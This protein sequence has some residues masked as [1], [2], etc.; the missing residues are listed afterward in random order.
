MFGYIRSGSNIEIWHFVGGI[1]DDKFVKY[2]IDSVNS[3]V[4]ADSFSDFPT[5]GSDN[6]FY[7]DKS[8]W[9]PYVWDGSAYRVIGNP[10]P[11]GSKG[12]TGD[13]GPA[14]SLS[15]GT[16][17][18]GDIADATI[19]GTPPTQILNLVLPKGDAGAAGADGNPT[20]TLRTNGVNNPVQDV[21]DFVDSDT[22]G[23]TY[24]SAGQVKLYTK[25]P[26]LFN[27]KAGT[28]EAIAAG[29][30]VGT[31][32]YTNS[33]LAGRESEVYRSGSLI[34]DFDQGGG[35]EY[36]IKDTDG[37]LNSTTINFLSPIQDGEWIKIK[38]V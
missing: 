31:T 25:S 33:K 36:A 8:T 37:T 2:G 12:D 17:T 7:I 38:L 28:S 10:G 15:I 14:N 20:V 35:V 22:I 6:T 34:S 3:V 11:I 18:S 16:V 13:T 26:V 30:V 23:V 4:R 19:T 27:G 9:T 5:I 1:T 29:I 32:S 24:V 21:L